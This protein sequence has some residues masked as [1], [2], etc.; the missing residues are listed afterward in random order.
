M[1]HVKFVI[2]LTPRPKASV[3]LRGS[4]AYNPS[5]KGMKNL[6]DHVV[7]SLDGFQ[8]PI[9]TGP[10]MVVAHNE[11]PI[12]VGIR[13]EKR[14]LM[15]GVSHVRRPDEDNLAKFLGDSLNGVVWEDDSLIFCVVRFKVWTKEKIGRICVAVTDMPSDY[16]DYEKIKTFFN[17]NYQI[18]SFQGIHVEF[19]A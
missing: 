4:R 8:F 15:H 7:S 13:G 2:P 10:V 16:I 17:K 19:C 12:P 1:S 5:A 3:R 11:I 6:R 14:E 18:E 9:F